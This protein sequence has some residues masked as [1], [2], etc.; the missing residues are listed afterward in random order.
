MVTVPVA[1]GADGVHILDMQYWCGVWD[2]P[3]IVL[4]KKEI[5][6][7]N[8]QNG[9]KVGLADAKYIL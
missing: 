7:G 2:F 5:K 8:F 6:K 9:K 1:Y 3:P 4:G